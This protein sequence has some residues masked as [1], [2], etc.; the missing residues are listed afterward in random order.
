MSNLSAIFGENGFNPDAVIE[1][2]APSFEVLPKGDYRI[3]V[4]A[5]EVKPTKANNGTLLILKLVVDDIDSKF[6]NRVVFDQIVVQHTSTVAQ[7]IGQTK[8]KH[9][10][11]ALGL[12]AV[13]DT[14]QLHSQ[15]VIA[16]IVVEKDD[17]MT[18]QKGEQCFRNNV[19]SY[20]PIKAQ[21]GNADIASE[22]IPF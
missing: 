22:D 15:P 18:S 9:L 11:Q 14:S 10:T 12:K 2:D 21:V 4:E 1:T 16:Q 19:K 17:Y 13:S 6:N 5:S 20:A 7:G 3:K 8:L